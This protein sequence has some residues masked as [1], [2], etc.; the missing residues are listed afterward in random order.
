M[1]VWLWI[2]L[3]SGV[4]YWLIF[5]YLVTFRR[6]NAAALAVGVLHMLLA[7][8]G[9]VAPIRS[10][11]DPNYAG[12]QIGLIRLEG[13]AVPLPATLVL[14]WA[15][16]SAWLAVIRG[17]GRWMKLIAVGDALLGLNLIAYLLLE[18][19][20]GRM[21][22]IKIQLGEHFT[23]AGTAAA[24]ILM[25]ILAVPLAA[26]AIWAGRRAQS[27]GPQSPLTADTQEEHKKP[28]QDTTDMGGFQYSGV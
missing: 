4:V 27:G 26:S 8:F 11:M 28:G 14:V 15:L 17:A 19:F 25:G 2:A 16:A 22:S 5:C 7:S 24:V 3:V 1:T 12:W 10:L 9:S 18:L 13:W 6:W 21:A 20:G 23:L